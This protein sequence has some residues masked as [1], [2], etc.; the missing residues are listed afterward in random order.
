MQIFIGIPPAERPAAATITRRGGPPPGPMGLPL[1]HTT[2]GPPG[3]GRIRKTSQGRIGG[4]RALAL[5]FPYAALVTAAAPVGPVE[6]A[7]KTLPCETGHGRGIAPK[8]ACASISLLRA[9]RICRRFYA[10]SP[11]V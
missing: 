8:A 7:T 11:Q 4:G 10:R 6:Q 3:Q 1:Y 9:S 2:R 5:N